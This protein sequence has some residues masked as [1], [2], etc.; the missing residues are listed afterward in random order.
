VGEVDIF[1]GPNYVLSVR[2]RTQQGFANVRRRCE[3]EPDLL[4]SG[5]AFVLYVL[6]DTVVDWYF[7][8]VA[9]LEEELER[10]EQRI[11]SKSSHARSIVE[12]LYVLKQK[13]VVLQHAV[14]SLL[15]AVSN[16]HGA[17]VPQICVGMEEYFRDI[18][19]HVIRMTTTIES[20]RD[21]IT[22]AIQVNLSL[23]SL[24][25]SEVTKKLAS[26]GAL[27]AVP[28][29]IAGIYGMNFKYMPE[30]EVPW[31]Y[32]T[33]VCAIIFIDFLIWCKFRKTGWL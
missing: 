11:F 21:M 27:F 23:I 3:T 25:E 22:T 33:V 28:T 12:E 31:G 5:S 20:V 10:I 29:A 2:N 6:I 4:N 24:S 1:V 30:L 16:L 7:P 26:Y 8:S 15:D 9:L 13:L 17:R 14:S 18:S 32:P 19:D